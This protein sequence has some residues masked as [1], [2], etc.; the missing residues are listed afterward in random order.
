MADYAKLVISA[1]FSKNSDYADPRYKE[2][3]QVALTPDVYDSKEVALST[4]D[5]ALIAQNEDPQTITSL[6]IYNSDAA[7]DIILAYTDGD[8][9]ANTVRIPAGR[10]AIIPDIDTTAAAVNLKSDS[11]TPEAI[12]FF[13]GT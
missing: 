3:F 7:I 5:L 6:V 11:G 4:T 9:N 12:V 10:C 8:A 13:C 2:T 1:Q